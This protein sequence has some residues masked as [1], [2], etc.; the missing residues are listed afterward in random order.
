MQELFT[1]IFYQPLLN[2]LVWVYNILPN[3]DLGLSIIILTIL[4][5]ALLAPLSWK[6]L[7]SQKQLQDI[8]PKIN[9]LKEQYK[10]DKQ[11]LAQAQMKYFQEQKI[12]PMASC[13]PLLVQF[14][15]LIALFYVFVNGLKG[16]GYAELLYPFVQNPGTLNHTMLGFLSLSENNNIILAVVVGAIQ[17]WQSKLMTAK[18]PPKVAGSKDEDMA[19]MMSK[20]MLY[21]MPV[22]TGVMT[23]QFP[24][25]LGVYWFFQ[26]V[27]AIGQQYLFNMKTKNTSPRVEVIPAK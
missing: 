8:Q 12:N 19:A 4:V 10:D 16:D 26:T 5:K 15:F 20:Q 18:R 1:A 14:P 3:H 11:G 22:I 13:L 2:L 27:L 9:E 25:G 17:F 24:G 21:F 6:Q 23:Y 7:E